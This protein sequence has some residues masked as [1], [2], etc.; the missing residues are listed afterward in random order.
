MVDW[1]LKINGLLPWIIWETLC[2]MIISYH[3]SSKVSLYP[4]HCLVKDT[5]VLYLV[6]K[7][8]R[9]Y[10]K[11][12]PLPSHHHIESCTN[13]CPIAAIPCS[14]GRGPSILWIPTSHLCFRASYPFLPYQRF[15]PTVF[16]FLSSMI[17][18]SV[19]FPWILQTCCS[20]S[21]KKKM[22]E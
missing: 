15:A 10:W 2:W 4:P 14:G 21:H 5:A 8:N 13:T 17:S 9:S 18:F 22:K 20:I 7:E 6:E 11:G 19:Q 12:P 3:L 1:K 16:P